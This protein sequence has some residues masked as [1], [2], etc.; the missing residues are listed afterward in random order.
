MSRKTDLTS[1]ATTAPTS[2]S[3][4]AAKASKT[5]WAKPSSLTLSGCDCGCGGPSTLGGVTS[6]DLD[7][8]V[9]PSSSVGGVTRGLVSVIPASRLA[10]ESY[11]GMEEG[12]VG[13]DLE[14]G[15]VSG[16]RGGGRAMSSGAG[17]DAHG[18]GAGEEIEEKDGNL[19]GGRTVPLAER[20]L[21][22]SVM[23]TKV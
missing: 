16:L 23:A 11:R 13:V 12:S 7:L 2:L 6:R 1:S 22:T 18:L 15:D 3:A 19:W 20:P 5:A 9:P 14:V 17:E 4:V 8:G 21:F 10:S